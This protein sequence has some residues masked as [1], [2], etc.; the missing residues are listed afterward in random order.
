[1]DIEMARNKA[2]EVGRF[3]YIQIKNT[4]M[5]KK[6]FPCGSVGKEST[7]NAGDLG[8][9]PGLER[10]PRE[11]NS[12]PL[13]YSGLENPMYYIVHGVTKSQTQLS[14]FHMHLKKTHHKQ[15]DIVLHT[16]TYT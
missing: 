15:V 13:Q 3:G 4:C 7:C 12:Y 8:L 16:N 2:G 9:I 5:L 6:G 1:M 14:K 11:V 10:S